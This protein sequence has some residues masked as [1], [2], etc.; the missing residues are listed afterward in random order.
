MDQAESNWSLSRIRNMHP[1]SEE[2]IARRAQE[3]KQQQQHS[4]QLHDD[5]KV[6]HAIKAINRYWATRTNNNTIGD[7]EL[8]RIVHECLTVAIADVQLY[9]GI[10]NWQGATVG[11]KEMNAMKQHISRKIVE[12]INN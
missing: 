6:H 1:Q 5:L 11:S 10:N 12:Y 9:W 8:D 2:Q 3:A 4:L 7:I